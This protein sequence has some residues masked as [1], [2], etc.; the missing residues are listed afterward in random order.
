MI[1]VEILPNYFLD[2]NLSFK[3]DESLMLSGQIAGVCYSEEG[4]N[5]LKNEPCEKTVKRINGTLKGGHHS[6][7]DHI[8]IS[9]NI[10]NIPKILAMFL[11]N[12]NQYTTSEKSARYTKM[13]EECGISNEEAFLYNKWVSIFSELIN[14]EYGSVFKPNKIKK[15]A[16]ENARYL[17][18]VFAQAQMV[19]TTSLRQLNYLASWMRKMISEDSKSNFE[20]K[21]KDA[22]REFLDELEHLNLLD[23]RLMQNEKCRQFSLFTDVLK[24]KE[25]FGEVYV[26]TYKGSYAYLAQAQRHRTIDYKAMQL[27]EKEFFVPPIIE[28]NE[29]LRNEWLKDIKSL[30][31]FIPQGELLMIQEMGKYSDFILKCKERLCSAAQLEIANLTEEILHKYSGSDD[32]DIASDVQKYL[33]GARCTF[34]DFQCTMDCHFMEGKKLTRKI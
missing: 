9:L 15:L 18:S 19:Y 11:N 6:V 4:F 7:Y 32:L 10:Q 22:M 28:N 29:V 24:S 13:N 27:D 16:M 31:D 14:D 3:K 33:H 20:V 30:E 21:L 8:M 34:P 2:E 5:A 26:T 25:Y 12:E 1:K 17:I 23:E